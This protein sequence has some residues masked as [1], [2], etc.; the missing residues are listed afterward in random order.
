[1][2]TAII[3]RRAERLVL[4]VASIVLPC[5]QSKLTLNAG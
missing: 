4:I 2:A 5:G 1:M 3:Q